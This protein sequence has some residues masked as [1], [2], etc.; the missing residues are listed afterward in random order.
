MKH[1]LCKSNAA[2]IAMPVVAGHRSLLA[3]AVHSLLHSRRAFLDVRNC[4]FDLNTD[5]AVRRHMEVVGHMN[6]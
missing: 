5:H 2:S 1:A 3:A 4:R 6:G